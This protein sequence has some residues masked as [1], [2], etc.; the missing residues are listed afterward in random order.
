M[1]AGEPLRRSRVLARIGNNDLSLVLRFHEILQRLWRVRRF[2]D[3]S[4]IDNADDGAAVAWPKIGIDD[5]FGKGSGGRRI[6]LSQKAVKLDQL[7]RRLGRQ[8]DIEKR[9]SGARFSGNPVGDFVRR[10]AP[11]IYIHASFLL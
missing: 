11:I 2:D 5:L 8:Y 3:S 6:I 10:G 1:Q 7:H 4:M 9:F